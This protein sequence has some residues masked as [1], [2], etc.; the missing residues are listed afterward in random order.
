MRAISS[1]VDESVTRDHVEPDWVGLWFKLGQEVRGEY[2]GMRAGR[3]SPA[4]EG[5]CWTFL[6]HDRYDGASGFV[7]I[8]RSELR[9]PAIP[10]PAAVPKPGDLPS[11]LARAVALFRLA[12]QRRQPAAAWK[13]LDRS[14]QAPPGGLKRPGTMVTTYEFGVD[15]TRKMTE[16]ART[17]GVSVNSYLFSAVARAIAPELEPGAPRW[18]TPYSMR[19]LVTPRRET[20]NCLALLEIEVD[21]TA[22]PGQV[23]KAIKNALQSHEHWGSWLFLNCGRFIGFANMRRIFLHELHRMEGRHAVGSFSNMG[24]WEGIGRWF[25]A[26]PVGYSSPLAIGVITCDGSLGLTVEAHPS[27]CRDP[28]WLRGLMDRLVS[29]TEV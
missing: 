23:H 14:W 7:H 19:G 4:G 2:I 16:K 17:H 12:A 3:P 21:R 11:L 5:I 9:R 15:R 29:E 24:P 18:M 10:V 6:P 26:P 1:I 8:L 27:I 25:T 28:A 20:D 22:N 13:T